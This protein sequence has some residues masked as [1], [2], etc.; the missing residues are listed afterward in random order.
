[1]Y[2]IIIFLLLGPRRMLIST[3]TGLP[4]GHTS[5]DLPDLGVGFESPPLHHQSQGFI[6][7]PHTHSPS[8]F[9]PPQSTTDVASSLSP[10]GIPYPPAYTPVPHPRT[11]VPP[12]STSRPTPLRPSTSNSHQST[13][14][15][16]SATATATASASQ[17][18]SSLPV[19]FVRGRYFYEN[20]FNTA[21]K[22]IN[23]NGE[24]GELDGHSVAKALMFM[25][26]ADGTLCH[27][28]LYGGI[29]GSIDYHLFD[30]YSQG[31]LPPLN[32]LKSS[33]LTGPY[34]A[35]Y[36][37][38]EKKCTADYPQLGYCAGGY[39]FK[40]WMR[41][42]V[43]AL[44][45]K[46]RAQARMSGDGGGGSSRTIGGIDTG[47]NISI[48][49]RVGGGGVSRGAS[50]G[51]GGTSIGSGSG[52]GVVAS[53]G[54]G[55]TA[56]GASVG[57]VGG[58]GASVGGRDGGTSIGGDASVGTRGANVWGSSAGVGGGD[59]GIS[60]ADTGSTGN[61]TT[62]ER[63]IA[64][65]DGESAEMGISRKRTATLSHIGEFRYIASHPI[66]VI[67]YLIFCLCMWVENIP[68]TVR[69]RLE[70]PDMIS[71]DP[72]PEDLDFVMAISDDPRNDQ[73][74]SDG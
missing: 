72:K 21:F 44:A 29:R 3:D 7:T 12:P 27:G 17:S 38:L 67:C 16:T 25:E 57:G 50:V 20:N 4:Q 70:D 59:V 36:M 63:I 58:S 30:A 65:V 71:M 60:G 26:N 74:D 45:S 56:S 18:G 64:D 28:S 46:L 8:T 10:P 55:V 14:T 9:N 11:V 48:A 2:H 51:N 32:R 42:R 5:F 43:A 13:S 19:A 34:A 47:I 68:P 52:A 49:A 69:Q 61:G 35:V 33:A 22:K 40:A 54:G 1:M 31:L 37:D 39:K 6:S 15:S 62:S 24:D 23:G 73:E 53:I 66:I 41:R